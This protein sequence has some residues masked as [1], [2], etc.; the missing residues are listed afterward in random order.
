MRAGTIPHCA[1]VDGD[2]ERPDFKWQAGVE[3]SKISLGRLG[4]LGDLFVVLERAATFR[5]LGVHRRRSEAQ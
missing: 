5:A 4:N 2:R 1:F 3:N